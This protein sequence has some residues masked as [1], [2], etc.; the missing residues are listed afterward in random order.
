MISTTCSHCG[1]DMASRKP[2]KTGASFC[3]R[4]ACQA[5]KQRFFRQRKRTGLSV[6]RDSPD[7]RNY[8]FRALHE[9]RIPCPRCGLEDAVGPFV[10]R[11]LRNPTHPCKGTG[12]IG[13]IMT[14]WMD[15]VH[16]ELGRRAREIE[17]QGADS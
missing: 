16:P 7:S 3:P 1:V 6:E 12:G 17:D 15:T 10:H 4:A 5:A 2:S 14:L 9:P 11:D 8:I 13:P